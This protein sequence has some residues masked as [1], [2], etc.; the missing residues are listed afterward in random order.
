MT[1]NA[2]RPAARLRR[3]LAGGVAALALGF[4]L[5]AMADEAPAADPRAG[6]VRQGVN[7]AAQGRVDAA[8]ETLIREAVDA[9]ERTQAALD[10]LEKGERQA[11]LDALAA[12]TGKLET[13][14]ARDPK[15]AL[16]PVDV[17]LLR[18]EF[19]GDAETVEAYGEQIDDL[20]DEGRYQEARALIRDFGSE[21]VVRTVNLPLAT[22]PDAL[23][24][25]AR[26]IHEGKD[27][28]ALA[29]LEGAL[30]AQVIVDQA[31]PLPP[32]RAELMIRQAQKLLE[33]GD[34]K[35]AQGDRDAA[36]K[37]PTA[38]E[39]LAAARR[40]LKLA[41]AFGYGRKSDYKELH[42]A[43][44]EL[45]EKVAAHEDAGG[46][47]KAMADK[48]AALRDRLLGAARDEARPEPDKGDKAE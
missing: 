25:A 38:A 27:K 31:I 19:P 28:E 10:A 37:A 1:D 47:F 14:I 18:I 3:A 34:G 9:L 17:Q 40:E 46:L 32:L 39:Y 21:L 7:D 5:A 45:E 20:T 33:Q 13:V 41:Q 30:S 44:D 36:A 16:A 23:L 29:A 26:L 2:K 12:A 24:E 6:A 8:S 4:G 11:A 15:L 48:F 42:E 22:Y 43:L 35:A